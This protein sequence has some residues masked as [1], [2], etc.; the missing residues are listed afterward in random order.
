MYNMNPFI[1]SG[2]EGPEYFCNRKS[3]I[4]KLREAFDNRRNITMFSLRR[5]GKS[6]LVKYH[7]EIIKRYADCIYSDLFP[8]QSF[9]DMTELIAK[10][11]ASQY[12]LTGKILF[13][14][15]ISIVKSMGASLSFNELTGAPEINFAV[16][17]IHNHKK[18]L[19]DIFNL[20]ETSN[21]KVL[22]ALDEF[23][24]IR[25][26]SEKNSEAYLRSLIQ[27]L[28]NVNFIF[29]GSNN[30][31]ME[32]IFT[33]SKKP[34]Y[35][36]TQYMMLDEIDNKEYSGFIVNQFQKGKYKIAINDAEL[37]LKI[38]R[39]HTYYVQYL[40]NRLYSKGTNISNEIIY[41]TL[42][43]ILQENEPVFSNY[44]NLLTNLQWKLVS[45]I[46][47]EDRIKEPLSISFIKKYDLNSASS[48]KRAL[49]SLLKKEIIIYYKDHFQLND[50]F[51]SIWLKN[52]T[53]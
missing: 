48:L 38:C 19:A 5:M 13:N 45:S 11:I 23:Q 20:L 17:K 30:S 51:F 14:K 22:I 3:E 15:I 18:N 47:K 7:F 35:Q 29:L 8:A 40:C 41:R 33:D 16:G 31:I 6:A 21:K 12:K 27:N 39:S 2:F 43:E 52:Y 32:S 9:E 44:K 50:L 26:F 42:D 37:I 4:N 36:S 49:D 46:S 53:L 1:V 28:K 25:T 34:F 10:S 24:I